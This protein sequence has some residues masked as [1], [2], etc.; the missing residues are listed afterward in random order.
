MRASVPWRSATRLNA[1]GWSAEFALP[2]TLLAAY[3]ENDLARQQIPLGSGTVKVQGSGIPAG[4]KVWVAGREVP[5]DPKGNFIAE[6]VLPSGTHTVEVEVLDS[7][8]TAFR[9]A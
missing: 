4:H 2:L 5:V 1:Q 6:E 7:Q 8:F 3:G 9:D